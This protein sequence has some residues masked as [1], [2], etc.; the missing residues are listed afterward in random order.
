M[1]RASGPFSQCSRCGYAAGACRCKA[2]HHH[3]LHMPTPRHIGEAVA[4]LAT[5]ALFALLALI[6]MGGAK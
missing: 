4:A 2:A 1:L 6:L 5:W 3:V